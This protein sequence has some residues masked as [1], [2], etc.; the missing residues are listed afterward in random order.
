MNKLRKV[1][2]AAA[3]VPLVIVWSVAASA[4]G[5]PSKPISLIVTWNAG[6]S[7][8]VISRLLADPLG[9]ALG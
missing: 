9:K 5:Y 4:Q 2:G 6:G 3:I 8:D 1:L 7:T